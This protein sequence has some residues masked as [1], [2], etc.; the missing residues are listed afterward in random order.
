MKVAD[1]GFSTGFTLPKRLLAKLSHLSIAMMAVGQYLWSCHIWWFL[2]PLVLP[3]ARTAGWQESEKTFQ[4]WNM[5]LWF[6]PDWTKTTPFSTKRK[7]YLET[8]LCLGPVLFCGAHAEIQMSSG[9]I[10]NL[11]CTL[12]SL[13]NN[14]SL[15]SLNSSTSLFANVFYTFIISPNSHQRFFL[16]FPNPNY[17]FLI[18]CK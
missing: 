10:C 3:F 5:E 14:L 8:I 17:P 7:F 12:F 6:S 4:K 2:L 18:N 13:Q 1:P 9:A 16:W 15:F 11:N